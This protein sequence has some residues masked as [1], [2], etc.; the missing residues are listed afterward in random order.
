MP[1]VTP[2]MIWLRARRVLRIRPP[3]ITETHRVTCTRGSA[4]SIFTSQNCAPKE[5][6]EYGLVFSSS[7][8][9]E[10]SASIEGSLA[11]AHHQTLVAAV[12]KL[13]SP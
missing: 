8:L 1:M 2:P 6:M 5:W 11:C 10:A 7:G 4:G 12:D 13:S 3:S 9:T